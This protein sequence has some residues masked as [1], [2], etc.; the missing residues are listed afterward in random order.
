[1]ME[2]ICRDIFIEDQDGQNIV[3]RFTDLDLFR[4]SYQQGLKSDL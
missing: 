3:I 1:M 4:K 2:R